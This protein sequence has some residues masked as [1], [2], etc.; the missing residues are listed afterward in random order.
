M[1]QM[2]TTAYYAFGLPIYVAIIATEAWVMHRRG[3]KTLSFAPSFGNLSAGLGAI[4]VG[5]FLGPALIFM[6][7]TGLTRLA[8]VHWAPGSVVPWI[9]AVVLADLGHYVHHRIDHRVAACW[10]VHEVHHQPQ[11]MNF[12]VAMRHAWFSDIYSWPFYGTLPLLGVPTAQFFV[13]TTL[14][15]FHALITHTSLFNFPSFYFFVTPRSHS[16][17]HA[18]NPRYIDKNFGAMLCIWDRLC[19][20]HVELEATEPPDYG[21]LRG[22]ATHDGVFAQWVEWRDLVRLAKE[23]PTFRDKLRVFVSRPG[24]NPAGLHC[25]TLVPA[26]ASETIPLASKTYVAVQF[27]FTLVGSL[28][29]FLLR[30]DHSWTL[31]TAAAFGIV[32]SLITLGGILDGRKTAWQQETARIVITVLAIVMVWRA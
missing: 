32:A 15:S 23:T 11:E 3:Q 10:A 25:E 8:L 19:G 29:V 4:V 2:E 22:Y 17:H 14:I 9:L 18:R 27:T 21:T 20:T 7:D 13:A 12:T 26:R 6:Y 28:Y 16:L 24:W 5:L 30:E 31:K 1:A